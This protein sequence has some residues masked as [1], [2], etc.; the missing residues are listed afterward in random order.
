MSRP[1][2]GPGPQRR[3]HSTRSTACIFVVLWKVV[4]PPSASKIRVPDD[5]VSGLQLEMY[6]SN[7]EA[8]RAT[9]YR[10]RT[11]GALALANRKVLRWS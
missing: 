5:P 3:F 4:V 1:R 6:V 8:A 2:G 7:R 11:S 9:K 10:L